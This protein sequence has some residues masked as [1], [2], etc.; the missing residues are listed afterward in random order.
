ME[1]FSEL[2]LKLTATQWKPLF[3]T[4]MTSVGG[5]VVNVEAKISFLENKDPRDL[6]EQIYSGFMEWYHLNGK[7]ATVQKLC[8]CLKKVQMESLVEEVND[9]YH[10]ACVSVLSKPQMRSSGSFE[11]TV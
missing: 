6:K 2:S 10:K 3:R 4:L 11:T 5:S 9:I 7:Y 1:V 8:D